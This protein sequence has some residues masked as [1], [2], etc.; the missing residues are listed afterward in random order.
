VHYVRK[1]LVKSEWSSFVCFFAVTVVFW[2]IYY[3][4][5]FWA[6]LVKKGVNIQ[7]VGGG[8]TMS[9]AKKCHF[10]KVT[11]LC[12]ISV[13]SKILIFS[14]LYLL[15]SRLCYSVVSVCRLWCT[16][17]IVAK[18]C[19]LE[20]KLLL[21]SYR[22]LYMRNQLLPNWMTL[23]FVWSCQPLRYIWSWVSRNPLEIS[24]WFQRTANKNWHTGN[25]MVM[26]PMKSHDPE[27]SNLWPQ[28]AQSAISQK[29]LEM[30]FSNNRWLLPILLWGSTVGYI[31][32]TA[33]LHVYFTMAYLRLHLDV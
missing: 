12:S 32:A 8:T 33:W 20:Q 28:Y 19:N 22:K 31:L 4:K 11:I 24:A 26:W 18:R 23:T 10:W 6:V 3:Q 13:K 27:R 7:A 9:E 2:S 16:D 15:R 14:Q 29:Q 25:E 1:K 17:C 30:L 21:T 5:T